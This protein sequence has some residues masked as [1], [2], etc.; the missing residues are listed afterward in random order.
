DLIGCAID[1]FGDAIGLGH[2]DYDTLECS[3]GKNDRK[4]RQSP[5]FAQVPSVSFGPASV[6]EPR[7]AQKP[8]RAS[9]SL[10]STS[11]LCLLRVLCG[12]S[13]G[14]QAFGLAGPDVKRSHVREG[15]LFAVEPLA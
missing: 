8:S 11:V 9:P 10:R 6:K 3:A 5:A 1:L 12:R 14:F 13:L 4:A 2:R 7:S 15:R